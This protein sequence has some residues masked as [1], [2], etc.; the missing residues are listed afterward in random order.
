MSQDKYE[1]AGQHFAS[2]PKLTEYVQE[3]IERYDDDQLIEGKDFDFLIALFQH[4]HHAKEKC[5]S[6]IKGIWPK[7]QPAFLNRC[8][9]TRLDDGSEDDISWKNCVRGIQ[10][11][12]MA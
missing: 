11:H 4:H 3:L 2:K 1:V 10:P 9:M 7:Y 5:V 8:F 6:E 12:A